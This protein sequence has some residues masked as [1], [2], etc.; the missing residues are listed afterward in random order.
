MNATTT[1]TTANTAHLAA[2]CYTWERPGV[3]L[4]VTVDAAGQV[5]GTLTVLTL[6]WTMPTDA[7][8]TAPALLEALAE[9]PVNYQPA[10][11]PVYLTRA[12]ARAMHKELSRLGLPADA[13]YA[14]A[15]E[16]TGRPVESLTALTE[17]EARAV[18]LAACNQASA[19][20][21]QVSTE[22]PAM[23]D[24]EANAYA[25]ALLR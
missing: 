13:R 6:D 7:E 10:P 4:A 2:G 19:A 17:P 11:A 5:A 18:W 16:L 14:L 20:A 9:V 8:L 15:A 22:P 21:E 12:R 25:A 24:E 1:R 23:T 3:A